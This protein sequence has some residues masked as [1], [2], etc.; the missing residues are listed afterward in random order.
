MNIAIIGYGKMGRLIEA[1]ALD[2]GHRVAAIVD[3]LVP[4]EAGAP[5]GAPVYRSMDDASGLA[6]ADAAIEFT[7]PDT[8][9]GN[10]Y[11]LIKRCIPVIVGTTG[12]LDH[13][14][15]IRAAVEAA[16]TSLLWASNFSLGVN[17][18]YRISAYAARLADPFPEYDAGGWEAHHN[19]KADSPSGTARTLVA[20][21]LAGMSRKT[22]PVWETL[23]RPPK[24]E[25]LHYPSLRTGSLPGV[26][27]LIFDSPADTIEITHTAR[28]REGFAA[29]A[30][31]AAEWLARFPGGPAGEPRRGVFTMDDVLTDILPG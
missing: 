6:A 26:H 2:R 17:L 19:K 28:N 31:R 20:G 29:G 7:R 23:D 12:W 11:A 22:T 4:P 30:L 9:P 15:E 16:G 25:E 10:L 21:V 1:R 27:T 8:A 18:F 3:P 24:A 14:A 5:S 13:L